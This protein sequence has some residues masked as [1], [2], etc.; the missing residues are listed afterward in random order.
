MQAHDLFLLF[1]AKKIVFLY[2]VIHAEPFFVQ[3]QPKNCSF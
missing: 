3:V 2:G 1:L